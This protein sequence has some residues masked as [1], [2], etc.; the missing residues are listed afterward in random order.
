M[1]LNWNFQK[2]GSNTHKKT[3]VRVAWIFSG[4]AQ[5]LNLKTFRV[6]QT[7]TM[8]PVMGGIRLIYNITGNRF[9]D[10]P[11]QADR[12]T[13]VG[14]LPTEAPS[15][16]PLPNYKKGNKTNTVSPVFITTHIF[17]IPTLDNIPFCNIM[18]V[19]KTRPTIQ[20]YYM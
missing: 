15:V 11:L 2:G 13:Y 14:C 5:C 16:F 17:K 20:G 6:Q 4:T 9:P 1:K 7:K 12:K 3:F 18:Q 19:R 8:Y 10:H